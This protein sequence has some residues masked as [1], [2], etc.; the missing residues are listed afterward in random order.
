M[1]PHGSLRPKQHTRKTVCS[2]GSWVL[3]FGLTRPAQMDSRLCPLTLWSLQIA[4]M[5]MGW[6]YCE[7]MIPDHQPAKFLKR[8]YLQ[9]SMAHDLLLLF[10]AFMTGLILAFEI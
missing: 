7:G 2:E 8:Q 9:M 6:H 4:S 10:W 5:A 1:P 3:W